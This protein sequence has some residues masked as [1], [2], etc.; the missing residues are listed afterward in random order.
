MLT[1][2]N[3]DQTI[4]TFENYVSRTIESNTTVLLAG[5]SNEDTPEVVALNVQIFEMTV[6]M[7]TTTPGA[8]TGAARTGRW[9]RVY[10]EADESPSLCLNC[11]SLK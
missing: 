4:K 8:T 6:L 7:T 1:I 10:S 9:V 2:E 5:A 3:T 11:V